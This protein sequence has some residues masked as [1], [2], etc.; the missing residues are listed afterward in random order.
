VMA[1]AGIIEWPIGHVV[2]VQAI[3]KARGRLR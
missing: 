2:V 3:V 1:V